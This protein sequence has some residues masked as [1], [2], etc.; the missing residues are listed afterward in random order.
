ME[1]KPLKNKQYILILQARQHSPSQVGICTII[2][3]EVFDV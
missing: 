3:S 1:K 2:N